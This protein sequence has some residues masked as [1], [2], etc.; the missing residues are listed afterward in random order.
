MLERGKAH[1]AR[2]NES[3]WVL[4][5][6]LPFTYPIR[7]VKNSG[8][9]KNKSTFLWTLS[10][11]PGLESFATAYQS[12]S[13]LSTYSEKGGRSKCDKLDRCRS[14]KLIV[15]PSSALDHSSLS[16]RSSSSVCSTILSRGSISDSWYLF[17]IS[18]R[19]RYFTALKH[20]H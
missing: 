5:R 17:C 14:A 20:A 8:T 2:M 15:P 11:T 6:E 9:C 1:F 3:S 12:S 18:M 7:R 19:Y 10:Q 4:A 13:V 16:H